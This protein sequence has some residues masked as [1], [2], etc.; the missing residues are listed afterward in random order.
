VVMSVRPQGILDRGDAR[1]IYR[2]V[3]RLVGWRFSARADG[4]DGPVVEE[5]SEGRDSLVG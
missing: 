5:P 3:R 1:R 4:R 2:F